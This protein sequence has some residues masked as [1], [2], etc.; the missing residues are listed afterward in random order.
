W[1]PAGTLAVLGV[2]RPHSPSWALFELFVIEHG[3][4]RHLG[5]GLDRPLYPTTF[6]DLI[7]HE[8]APMLA[9]LDDANVVALVSDGGATHP[10]RF[11]LDGSA[12]P[13]A[14]GEVICT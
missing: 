7:D 11:G 5:P 14:G 2:D 1:S 6:G 12:E 3:R 8:A 13:L 4:P 10:Y 9:W